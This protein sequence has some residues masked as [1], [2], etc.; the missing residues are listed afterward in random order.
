MKY[1]YQYASQF[2]EV[3]QYADLT[4]YG[5]VDLFCQ[6]NACRVDMGLV[7]VSWGEYQSILKPLDYVSL[8]KN[9]VYMFLARDTAVGG[10]ILH[11]Q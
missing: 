3:S 8:S 7:P 1:D 10:V 6:L 11:K 9:L 4:L 5:T 2:S